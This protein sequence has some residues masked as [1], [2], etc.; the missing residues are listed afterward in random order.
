MV[1]DNIQTPQTVIILILDQVDIFN[2]F[3]GYK[4]LDYSNVGSSRNCQSSKHWNACLYEKLGHDPSAKQKFSGMLSYAAVWYA[5][6][7]INTLLYG[8]IK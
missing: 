7:V 3:R 8:E 2:H 5:Q 6:G 1:E 4:I